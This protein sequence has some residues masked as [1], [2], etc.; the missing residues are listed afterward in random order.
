M[1]VNCGCVHE[2]QDKKYGKGM[3]AVTPVNK[4]NVGEV[5]CTACGRSIFPS[6]VSVKKATG[7]PVKKK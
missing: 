7:K 1:A 3:R 2:Y 6:S 5:R 4:S